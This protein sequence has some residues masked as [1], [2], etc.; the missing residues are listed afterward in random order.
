MGATDTLKFVYRFLSVT[1]K[2]ELK[3]LSEVNNNSI[4]QEICA[5][6]NSHIT[7]NRRKI[8]NA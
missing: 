7:K 8:K 2:R 6:L 4:N 5:A 3:K 1:Q